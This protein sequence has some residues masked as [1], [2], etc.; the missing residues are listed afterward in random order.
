M[1]SGMLTAIREF[2]KDSFVV[3]GEEGLQTLQVGD[4]TVWIEQ[5]PYVVL[6]LVLRGTP[7]EALKGRMRQV[8]ESVHERY[9]GK[10]RAYDGNPTAFA[11]AAD[12]LRECLSSGG[13]KPAATR[14]GRTLVARLVLAAA[15]A[16][17]IAWAVSSSARSSRRAA[18][19]AD[20]LERL[21]RQPGIVVIQS[22]TR[23][24]KYFVRLLR[25]PAAVE[26][27]SVIAASAVPPEE[28]VVEER[29][30]LSMDPGFAARRR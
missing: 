22:G 30:F 12:L 11:D 18:A 9:A 20:C 5:S 13:P 6:A 8:L 25:D 2:V 28:V 23:G 4:L 24:G 29:A 16:A 7:L 17:L 15:A 3:Q 14:R 21:D 1:V 27:S 10:L 19:W 26:P